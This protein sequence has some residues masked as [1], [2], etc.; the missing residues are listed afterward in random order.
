MI[1][2]ARP[3]RVVWDRSPREELAP[4]E[5]PADL[6][7]AAA[8]QREEMEA[9]QAK[10]GGTRQGAGEEGT[11]YEAPGRAMRMRSVLMLPHWHA[12]EVEAVPELGVAFGQ[13]AGSEEV[14]AFYEAYQDALA[15][16][17]E[18][19]PGQR[20]RRHQLLG[21]PRPERTIRAFAPWW[22]P[23]SVSNTCRGRSGRS[24]AP[25]SWRRRATGCCCCRSALPTGCRTTWWKERCTT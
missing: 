6:A 17:D 18:F 5:V 10:H 11:I 15:E 7:E 12:I 25:G 8:R 13:S 9:I 24:T 20:W 3:A 21:S 1:D 4:L 19:R 23:S 14:E 2:P 16:D 22:F